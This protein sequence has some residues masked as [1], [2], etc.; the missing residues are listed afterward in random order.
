VS[1]DLATRLDRETAAAAERD[2]FGSPTF[3][4]GGELHFGNDR[5]EFGTVVLAAAK[6]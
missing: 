2:V 6:A 4:V 3:V 5:L 1:G